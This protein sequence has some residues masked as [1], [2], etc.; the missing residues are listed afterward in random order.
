[1]ASGSIVQEYRIITESGDV[2]WVEDHKTSSFTEEG[3]L[4]GIDGV[5]FDITERRKANTAIKESE[6]SLALA[7]QIAEI[8]SWQ[9]KVESGE[10]SW[11]DKT[12]RLF[13]FE[14]G[15]ID[16]KYEDFFDRV[17]PDDR[18]VVATTNEKAMT[19]KEPVD[20]EYRIVA[21]DGITRTVRS[22]AQV[23]YDKD[24][25][26]YR[27]LGTIQDITE[28]KQI[29]EK[30][31]IY[32]S[33]MAR[34]ERLASLG[35]LSAIAAHELTQPLTVINLSLENVMDE[36]EGLPCPETVYKALKSCLAE[37]SDITSIIDKFRSFAR[38]SSETTVGAVDLKAVG[39]RTVNLLRRAG[40]RMRTNLRLEG[41]DKLPHVRSN[42]KDWEQLFFALI[43]NAIWAGDDQKSRQVV[44]SGVIKDDHIELRF[45]DNCGGIAPENLDR[46]FEPFFT[47]KPDGQGTGLGLCLVRDIV[48]RIGGK[49]HVES[50]FGEGSTFIVTLP[51]SGNMKS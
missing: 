9:W 45:S 18:E 1:M 7:Q 11:S 43:D 20:Y 5:V 38:T 3:I 50:T 35:T 2:R 42:E 40:R 46:I 28:Q 48:F 21:A 26:P 47:T 15:E 32:R 30:L 44:I 27:F 13:G 33:E 10:V 25:N 17:H 4:I 51:V 49:I 8:G 16:P 29:E 31:E 41:M 37:M 24:D 6:A 23:F 36:L 14:P 39:E 19:Q 22:R 34:A 12:Y